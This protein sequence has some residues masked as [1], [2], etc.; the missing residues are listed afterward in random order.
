[1]RS[2]FIVNKMRNPINMF[3]QSNK[4]ERAKK[5]CTEKKVL[6]FNQLI[7]FWHWQFR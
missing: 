2:I 6:R 4:S 3:S 7:G 1:M 5:K